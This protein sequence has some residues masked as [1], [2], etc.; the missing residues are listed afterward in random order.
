MIHIVCKV[1]TEIWQIL[2][3]YNVARMLESLGWSTHTLA[4]EDAAT[5]ITI[6]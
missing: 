4:T 2:T 6:S 3:V 1:T 5:Y